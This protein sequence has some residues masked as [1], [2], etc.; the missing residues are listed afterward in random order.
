MRSLDFSFNLILPAATMALESTQPLTEMSTMNLS[1]GKGRLARKADNFTS[2]CEPTVWKIWDS[3]RLTNLSASA[4]C[5]RDSFTFLRVHC[6]FDIAAGSQMPSLYVRSSATLF[7]LTAPSTARPHQSGQFW[8]TGSSSL[9][10][11]IPTQRNRRRV[12]CHRNLTPRF[13][14]APSSV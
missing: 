8:S 2:I 7:R 14:L 3:R 1:G 10:K 6:N 12:P 11:I 4:A 5:Y 13:V 9:Y